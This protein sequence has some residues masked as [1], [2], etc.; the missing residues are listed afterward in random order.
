MKCSKCGKDL[1]LSVPRL[2]EVCMRTFQCSCGYRIA[3]SDIGDNC[4]ESYSP[5]KL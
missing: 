5:K 2:N 1:Y 4:H 3:I